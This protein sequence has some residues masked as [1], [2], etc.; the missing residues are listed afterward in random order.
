[1]EPDRGAWDAYV[2]TYAGPRSAI[3]VSQVG[4]RLLATITSGDYLAIAEALGPAEGREAELVPTSATEFVLLGDTTVLDA[5]AA[6][7]EPDPDGRPV[8]VLSGEPFGVRQ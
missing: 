7:F 6:A 8:L 2:G 5:Q 4:D 3:R 1:V